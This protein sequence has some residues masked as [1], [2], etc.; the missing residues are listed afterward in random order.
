MIKFACDCGIKMKH[1]P[2]KS[3]SK[4]NNSCPMFYID[5]NFCNGK[6]FYCEEEKEFLCSFCYFMCHNKCLSKFTDKENIKNNCEC[7][8]RIHTKF[9]EFIF[10]IP[11]FEYQAKMKT[12]FWPIQI[13]NLMFEKGIFDNISQNLNKIILEYNPKIPFE[14]AQY[15]PYLLENLTNIF[16]GNLKLI[17]IKK[18]FI[19]FFHLNL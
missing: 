17:I 16:I 9:N 7:S 12:K 1:V 6:S 3:I 18:S 14:K 10:Q 15:F 13:I 11:F 5:K 8:N 2:N 19:I 4:E